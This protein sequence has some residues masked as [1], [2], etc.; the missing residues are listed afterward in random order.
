M[1]FDNDCFYCVKDE[2][3]TNIMIEIC[4]L[5]ASTLYLLRNRPIEEDVL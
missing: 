5:E 4:K 1:S 2:R 3:L